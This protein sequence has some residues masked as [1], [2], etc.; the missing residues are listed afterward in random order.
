ME[1]VLESMSSDRFK[2]QLLTE[3]SPPG[4]INDQNQFLDSA[5]GFSG[6]AVL[7]YSRPSCKPFTGLLSLKASTLGD[8]C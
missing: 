6:F 8:A 2:K 7:L 4:Q 3:G 1:P 5:A